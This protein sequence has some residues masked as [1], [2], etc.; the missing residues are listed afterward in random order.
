MTPAEEEAYREVRALLV[1]LAPVGARILV[2]EYMPLLELKFACDGT[3]AWMGYYC[4]LSAGHTG[5]CYS[6]TKS[7]NFKP[8]KV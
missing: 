3:V 5:E 4:V 2:N 6:R 7:V 8:E 1:K